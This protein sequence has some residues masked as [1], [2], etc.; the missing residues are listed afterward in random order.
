MTCSHYKYLMQLAADG[1]LDAPRRDELD[2]H[3][4]ACSSCRR[5]FE[6]MRA[7]TSLATGYARRLTPVHSPDAQRRIMEAVAARPAPTRVPVLAAIVQ[8]P[9]LA[10][11][12]AITAAAFTIVMLAAVTGAVHA[13]AAAGLN[14][15]H[16]QIPLA[17]SLTAG[18]PNL[19]P[20][21]DIPAVYRAWCLPGLMLA[22][23]V[24]GLLFAC[25]RSA[26]PRASR[27]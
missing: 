21:V 3:L 19:L 27:S 1:R 23:A 2:T 16:V 20:A 4:A 15:P 5:S 26:S 24:N 11:T 13:L 25:A 12:I 14:L 7:L 6:E 17:A 22:L 18:T 8:R 9:T 10:V